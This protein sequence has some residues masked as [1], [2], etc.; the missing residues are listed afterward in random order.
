MTPPLWLIILM[1]NYLKR[2][3]AIMDRSAICHG[4]NMAVGV[5]IIHWY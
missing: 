3:L 4:T 5:M 2:F 1:M